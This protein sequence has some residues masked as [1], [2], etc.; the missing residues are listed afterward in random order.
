MT[1]T[2][3]DPYAVSS[4]T[5]TESLKGPPPKISIEGRSVADI[6]SLKAALKETKE[7]L[8]DEKRLEELNQLKE[9]SEIRKIKKDFI[10]GKIKN[11]LENE[12][13]PI[14]EEREQLATVTKEQYSKFRNK[15]ENLPEVIKENLEERLKTMEKEL[16]GVGKENLEN[17]KDAFENP[18][19]GNKTERE[20]II[21]ERSEADKRRVMR[22]FAQADITADD[23]PSDCPVCR[24]TVYSVDRIFANKRN[25]HTQ[26]FKCV[27]CCKKLTAVNYN[28]H[29][30]QLMCK[31]HYF[32]IVHPEIAA[33]MDPATIE[34]DER[35]EEDEEEYAISSKPKQ[36]GDDVI[37]NKF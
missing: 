21:I 17:I 37:K 22:T 31:F 34:E 20:Q 26:C 36:L 12:T 29:E 15:F 13:K 32:E 16:M 33:T 1:E 28:I 30:E 2:E 25:Y 5:D 7:A 23:A 4:D 35:M 6:S 14:D 27:K 8:K 24:K 3:E 11:E 18:Q 10:E 19:E 9:K